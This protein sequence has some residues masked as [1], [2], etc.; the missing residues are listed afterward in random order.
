MSKPPPAETPAV[1]PQLLRAWP[2]PTPDDD[3]TKQARG[4]VCVVGGAVSTPG[5]VLLAGLAAL[6]V[7]AGRLQILTVEPTA[8]ALGVAVPEAM[9]VGL[10]TAASGSLSPSAAGRIA[11]QVGDDTTLVLGPGLLDDDDTRGLVRT[12][13]PGLRC[14]RLVLDAHALTALAEHETLLGRYDALVLTPNDSELEALLG[15]E[16][17]AGR[18]GAEKVAKR[19]GAVVATK[20]WA[21]GR[22]GSAWRDEA[23]GIG[24]G[25]SGSGDVLAGAIGGLLARGAEPAQAAV[26][27]Q[28]AHAAAGDRLAARLGRLG[29]VARELLDEL[30]PILAS[31]ST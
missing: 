16:E 3:G 1:T 5:A 10:P 2:L 27:G 14:R 13:L 29:F 18:D 4:T 23:G 21:V 19:Y 8:V 25:T 11:E 26:W 20:G 15:G 17:L 6:R 24:L 22:D 28:Y 9:V 12:V 7:G 30:G 31:L